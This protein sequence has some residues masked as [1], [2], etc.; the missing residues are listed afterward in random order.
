MVCYGSPQ[1]VI[2]VVFAA[3]GVFVAI[4]FVVIGAWAGSEVAVERAHR[5]G[6]W[7]RTRQYRSGSIGCPPPTH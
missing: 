1:I 5:F 7:L 2:G 6:Y 3:L 4:A